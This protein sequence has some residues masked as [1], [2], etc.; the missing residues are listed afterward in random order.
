MMRT[1]STFIK[2]MVICECNV[3][4]VSDISPDIVTHEKVPTSDTMLP[5]DIGYNSFTS[6]STMYFQNIIQPVMLLFLQQEGNGCSIRIMSMLLSF[7]CKIFHSFPDWHQQT[8]S[9]IYRTPL[10]LHF[11]LYCVNNGSHHLY[12]CMHARVHACINAQGG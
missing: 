9:S 3:D 7:P 6:N 1:G 4:L 12:D 5:G 10:D 2:I 11:M 8:L